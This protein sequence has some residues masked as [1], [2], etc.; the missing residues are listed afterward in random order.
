MDCATRTRLFQAALVLLRRL[1]EPRPVA[2]VVEDL[3]WAGIVVLEELG[4]GV[5]AVHGPRSALDCQPV[6]P[7]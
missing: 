4:H 3:Q 7:A 1:G 6:R 2:L 5:D